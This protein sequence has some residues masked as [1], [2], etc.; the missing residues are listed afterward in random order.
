MGRGNHIGSVPRPAG[1]T[2]P[3]ERLIRSAGTMALAAALLLASPA[4]YGF[5]GSGQKSDPG[6]DGLVSQLKRYVEDAYVKGDA[7]TA[8]REPQAL[9]A[10]G[11]GEGDVAPLQGINRCLMPKGLFL[12][13]SFADSRS[14]K[15]VVKLFTIAKQDV[16]DHFVVDGLKRDTLFG[17]RLGGYHRVLLGREVFSTADASPVAMPCNLAPSGSS[18]PAWVIVIPYGS[19]HDL[20]GSRDPSMEERLVEELTIHEITHIEL[21]TRDELLPFLAQ[22]GYRVDDYWPIHSVEDLVGYLM[23][24]RLTYHSLDRLVLQRICYP[25]AFYGSSGNTAHLSALRQI[26]GEL[27]RLAREIH[28]LDPRYPSDVL[29]MSDQQCYACMAL[30]YRQGLKQLIA[31]RNRQTGAPT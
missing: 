18:A 3:F 28:G 4:A 21:Q 8:A 6:W 27:T 16:F 25:E 22:F 15:P 23:T 7:G 10:Y 24:K 9:A 14:A 2:G 30:L 5:F 11:I 31:S 1:R 13:S 17:R 29:R 19:L 12:T 20:Y 26:R